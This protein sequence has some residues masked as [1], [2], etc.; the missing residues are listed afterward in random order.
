MQIVAVALLQGCAEDPI[1]QAWHHPFQ[2]T[3]MTRGT[4]SCD[5]E[6]VETEPDTPYLFFAVGLGS[7]N[8]LTLYWCEEVKNCPV[9][10]WVTIS[11]VDITLAHAEGA[12]AQDITLSDTTCQVFWDGIDAELNGSTVT[13]TVSR[14]F[15]P[16]IFVVENPSDCETIVADAVNVEC[17]EVTTLE[18]VVA[19]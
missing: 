19:D 6:M 3:S 10:P 18:G 11:P 13:A 14:W 2:I 17:D 1:V 7:P 8:V 12:F 15:P 5:P 4:G 16:D 9:A